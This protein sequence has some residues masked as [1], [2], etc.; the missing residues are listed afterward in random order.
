[1]QPRDRPRGVRRGGRSVRMRE[2]H[3]AERARG[4]RSPDL[5]RGGAGRAA[6]RGRRPRSRPRPR[7]R[8]GV[9]ERR[10]LSV[11]HGARQRHLRPRPPEGPVA[12][13][14]A[15]TGDGAARRRGR[16]RPH[17]GHLSRPV[18]LGDAA[19]GGDPARPDQQP[20][21]P[22]AGRTLPG[23]GHG[24]EV[25]HAPASSR[26]LRPV[27]QDDLLHHPRPRRGDPA[28]GQGRGDDHPA[29]DDQ[30]DHRGRS[31]PAP[32]P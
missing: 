6:P 23:H 31:A 1:M 8:G 12:G 16:P 2:E 28:R 21:G 3:P 4:V 11:V 22:A 9:P 25:H 30:D 24:L 10:A 20:Q 26:H 7:P 19:P 14:S 5:G 13:G 17:R 18:V 15:R 32:A 29:R 27:P